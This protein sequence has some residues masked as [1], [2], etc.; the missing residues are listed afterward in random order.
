VATSTKK[1]SAT[2]QRA[3]KASQSTAKKP[4]KLALKPSKAQQKAPQ[5]AELKPAPKTSASKSA[6]RKGLAPTKSPA[7]TS[8]PTPAAPLSATAATTAPG[9]RPSRPPP[10]RLTVRTPAGA[11]ELK[12]K[13]GALATATAQ[14]RHLKR[15]LQKSFYEI[16]SI[17]RDIEE[18]RLYEVKG[19][20]SF[21]AFLEREIDLGKQTGLRLTRAVHV[22]QRDAAVQVGF[23]R[24]VAALAVFDG[25]VDPTAAPP[26]ATPT[27]SG[28]ARSPI[29]FHKQ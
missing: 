8:P 7:P 1:R 21:E 16:G 22:F 24:V 5:K 28:G 14:I 27:S 11:D 15:T 20:G 23:D 4:G 26:A 3:P 2:T 9:V 25:E 29:P 6:A 17:L 10:P 18:R 19:Y 12:Q 13:I